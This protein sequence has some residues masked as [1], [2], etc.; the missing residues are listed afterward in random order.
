HLPVPPSPSVMQASLLA[1]ISEAK[2]ERIQPNTP[3]RTPMTYIIKPILVIIMSIGAAFFVGHSLEQPLSQVG[4]RV[5]RSPDAG[6]E[7]HYRGAINAPVTL[8]EYGD[9]ACPSCALYNP[10]INEVL[11][12]YAGKVRLEYRHF[13]LTTIHPNAVSASVA[14]EAAGQ[15]GRYWEMHD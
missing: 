8:V 11:Q 13:P 4:G 2:L 15:Q 6:P 5:E 9:Y 3:R 12:Q 10:V 7:G 14:A 1:A